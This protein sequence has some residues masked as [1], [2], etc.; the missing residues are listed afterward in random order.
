MERI[1][2]FVDRPDY[3]CDDLGVKYPACRE[4]GFY[5]LTNDTIEEYYRSPKNGDKLMTHYEADEFDV[6]LSMHEVW[7]V[8]KSRVGADGMLNMTS[9][10]RDLA[11]IGSEYEKR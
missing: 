8:L 4:Y 10:E 3:W 9:R 6:A 7:D 2:F 5:V 1:D 11:F